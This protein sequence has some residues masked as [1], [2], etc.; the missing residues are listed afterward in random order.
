MPGS[1]LYNRISILLSRHQ[2]KNVMWELPK[3]VSVMMGEEAKRRL[4]IAFR[5]RAMFSPTISL[6]PVNMTRRGQLEDLRPR[7]NE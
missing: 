5:R 6:V 2:A 4:I 1:A 7:S 3:A